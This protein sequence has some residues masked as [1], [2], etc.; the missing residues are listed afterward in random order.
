[1]G[2]RLDISFV[3]VAGEAGAIIRPVRG[4]RTMS[5]YERLP[6]HYNIAHTILSTYHVTDCATCDAYRGRMRAHPGTRCVR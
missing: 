6:E 2:K 1:M 3:A 5:E 4:A